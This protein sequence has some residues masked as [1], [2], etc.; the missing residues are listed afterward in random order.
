MNCIQIW[1]FSVRKRQT[2]KSEEKCSIQPKNT[3]SFSKL[4]FII[5]QIQYN[6]NNNYIILLQF[7][8]L[9][10]LIY[11]KTEKNS[12]NETIYFEIVFCTKQ[13]VNTNCVYVYKNNGV[14]VLILPRK[15]NISNV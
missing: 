1:C 2:T 3:C 12:K 14:F 8:L 6:N 10:T 13:K 7:I 15:V 11:C 9:F 5:N 4:T